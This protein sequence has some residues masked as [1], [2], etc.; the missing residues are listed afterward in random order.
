MC[1]VEFAAI[2]ALTRA[3]PRPAVV[4]LAVVLCLPSLAVTALSVATW[5]YPNGPR[6]SYQAGTD[7]PEYLPR[8][9]DVTGVT[10]KQRSVNLA[11][12][13]VLPKAM[14]S[15]TVDR[16]G[17]VTVR[18][19]AFPIWRVS[20][21]GVTVPTSGPLITFN[22]SPGTYRLERILLWQEWVGAIISALALIVLC[23]LTFWPFKALL[24]SLPLL[25]GESRPETGV[26]RCH[27]TPEPRG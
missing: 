23:A 8:G 27:E 25:F 1:V 9:F 26:G 15:I 7:A 24:R 10:G 5:A 16:V 13:R 17:V 11:P 14:A 3:P 2:T 4:A 6:P 19:A 22:A 12:Y 20:K 18:R 21:G